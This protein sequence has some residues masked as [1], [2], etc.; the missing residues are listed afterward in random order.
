MKFGAFAFSEEETK[1]GFILLFSG[2]LT[3][4]FGS[5]FSL[6][7]LISCLLGIMPWTNF[8]SLSCT[9]LPFA[10]L[11]FAFAAKNAALLKK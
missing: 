3:A 9:A 4:L 10:L 1:P 2:V 5:V 6:S 8:P 7:G 11:G